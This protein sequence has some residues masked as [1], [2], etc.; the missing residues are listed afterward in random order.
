VPH[1]AGG[2]AQV[3][4]CVDEGDLVCRSLREIFTETL[5]VLQRGRFYPQLLC[6]PQVTGRVVALVIA[7]F[8]TAEKY[9]NCSV[10]LRLR[11]KGGPGQQ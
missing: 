3:F 2:L 8:V 5:T 6:D 1:D 9:G 4:G 7:V 10:Q 11:C